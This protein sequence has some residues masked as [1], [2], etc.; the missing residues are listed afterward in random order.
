MNKIQD[1]LLEATYIEVFING[2]KNANTTTILKNAKVNKGSMYHYFKDKKDLI[3]KMLKY[4]YMPLV[5][6][7]YKEQEKDDEFDA[8]IKL[9]KNSE[10]IVQKYGSMLINLSI[11]MNALDDDFKEILNAINK[12][13]YERFYSILSSLNNKIIYHDNIE[14]LV[15]FIIITIDGATIEYKRTQQISDFFDGIGELIEYLKNLKVS[16]G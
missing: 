14:K 5:S 3:L 8:L 13:R 1:R 16:S 12:I 11:E 7:I 15:K 10:L 9:I 6:A 4:K 2:Y